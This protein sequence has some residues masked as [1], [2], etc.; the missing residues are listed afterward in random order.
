MSDA[1]LI[2]LDVGG[3]STRALVTTA[4]G[5]RLGTGRARGAN[6]TSHPPA[7][8]A[9][10]LRAALDAALD[11]LDPSLVRAGVIGV[12]G[13]GKLETSPG[14]AAAFDNAWRAAGL[15][16]GYRLVSDAL[17]AYASGTAAPDGTA[18]IAGTGAIA[19]S[20]R[21]RTL[22]R[23][24]DGHGWLLGDDGSGFW[25]GRS[26]ARAALAVQDGAEPDGPLAASVR[27]HLLGSPAIAANPRQTA[28][29]IVQAVNA[30]PPVALAALAPLVFAAY[31]TDPV[32]DRIVAGAAEH[33]TATLALSR[34]G[35]SPEP[36]VLAGGLLT[37]DTPLSAALRARIARQWPGVPVR[38]AR[39]GAAAAAWLAALDLAG[40][41]GS[42]PDAGDTLDP[43]RL[44]ATLLGGTHPQCASNSSR[45]TRAP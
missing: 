27:T 22:A 31:G 33:L 20:V 32:A 37:A 23:V 8:A 9:A 42:P 12:A 3:T 21:D 11:G 30:G 15:G 2:G 34:P 38:T 28:S 5:I 36:V 40:P 17:V 24:V 1:L 29:D 26:A 14:A 13:I 7:T 45:S 4:D 6:P 39:D 10:E 35:P 44:H 25:L 41:A 16:C 18:L 19:V 43:A